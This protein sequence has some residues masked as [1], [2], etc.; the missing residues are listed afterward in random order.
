[1]EP[2][3][4][5][6][7]EVWESYYSEDG[8]LKYIITCRSRGGYYYLYENKGKRFKKLGSSKSPDELAERFDLDQL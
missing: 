4:P 2:P 5:R 8:E 3:Y 1:M 6:D 7:E